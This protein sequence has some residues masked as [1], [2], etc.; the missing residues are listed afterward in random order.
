MTFQVSDV[1]ITSPHIRALALL[2][3]LISFGY[4]TAI[5]ALVVNTVAGLLH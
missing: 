4:N 3:G 2:H 5:L 1:Q